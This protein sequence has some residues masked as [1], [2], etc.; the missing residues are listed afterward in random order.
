MTDNPMASVPIFPE[1]RKG[2]DPIAVDQYL[3]GLQRQLAEAQTK[4][5]AAQQQLRNAGHGPDATA[6]A[7]RTLQVARE[8]AEKALG[9][10]RN[11]AKKILA[12]GKRRAA[13]VSAEAD[14]RT[15]KG[16]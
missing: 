1:R 15:E 4:A 7:A 13:E 8:T 2:Y 5:A 14:K 6:E 16:S 11:H 3:H 10:A 9:E 12:E